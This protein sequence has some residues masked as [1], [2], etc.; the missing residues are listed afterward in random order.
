MNTLRYTILVIGTIAWFAPFP[1]YYTRGGGVLSLAR[2]QADE[3]PRRALASYGGRSL[4]A[5]LS[6]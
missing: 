2:N 4:H 1:F 5:I 3:R 6:C